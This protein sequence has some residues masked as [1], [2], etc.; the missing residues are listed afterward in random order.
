MAVIAAEEERRR[1]P[2][3]GALGWISLGGD[4]DLAVAIRT[5]AAAGGRV[6]YHAGCG[7]VADSDPEVELAES[8]AKAR[9]FLT[10]LGTRETGMSLSWWNG[11]SSPAGEVR[12]APDDAGFL[13]GDGLFETLRVDGGRAR[14]VG[15]HLDRLL[16]RPAPRRDR[17]PRE[18]RAPWSGPWRRSPHAAPR[19][20][21]RMR[22]TVTPRRRRRLRPA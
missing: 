18:P 4:L 16:R 6:A 11:G 14:D 21:A 17:D 9:A 20:V 5:A 2:A 7:I 15:A 10:A 13:F 12:I 1:G 8:A 19:P 3:M 22:I